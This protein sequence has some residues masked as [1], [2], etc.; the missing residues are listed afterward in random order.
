MSCKAAHLSS[1]IPNTECSNVFS[2]LTC[3]VYL[4]VYLS[5]RT[6]VSTVMTSRRAYL[7]RE[8]DIV[9]NSGRSTTLGL[10]SFLQHTTNPSISP[11]TIGR[12]WYR[13]IVSKRAT[14]RSS[15]IDLPC[16]AAAFTLRHS[17]TS[18]DRALESIGYKWS[19]FYE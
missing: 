15:G 17:T 13:G 3:S 10:K 16:T 12:H 9:A 11:S 7:P 18:V 19:R 2:C 1:L 8:T 14:F 4:T 5:E 6:V